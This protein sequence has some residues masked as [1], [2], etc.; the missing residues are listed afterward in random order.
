MSTNWISSR[1]AKLVDARS[2]AP[3]QPIAGR[4]PGAAASVT[5]GSKLDLMR[6]IGADLIHRLAAAGDTERMTLFVQLRNIQD[7]IAG[8][9][10]RLPTS[11][12]RPSSLSWVDSWR[13]DASA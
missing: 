3:S 13:P 10:H 8:M 7:Q 11:G 12:A 6:M 2:P 5:K 4:A 9:K 1:P